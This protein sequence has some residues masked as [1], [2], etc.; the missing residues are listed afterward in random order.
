MIRLTSADASAQPV[1][2][3]PR[4][5]AGVME[6]RQKRAGV[7]PPEYDSYTQVFIAGDKEPFSVRETPEE[8]L[9]LLSI[10]RGVGAPPYDVALA[11]GLNADELITIT[12]PKRIVG[13]DQRVRTCPNS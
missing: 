6:R 1:Y 7:Q 10:A 9:Y 11:S 3:A 13:P 5:I 8:V 4:H 12:A 2:L